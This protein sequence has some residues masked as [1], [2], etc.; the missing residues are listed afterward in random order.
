[1]EVNT[2]CCDTFGKLTFSC[3]CSL[4]MNVAGDILFILQ[5]RKKIT[6][7]HLIAPFPRAI[8][9]SFTTFTS[10]NKPGTCQGPNFELFTIKPKLYQQ[11]AISEQ[12]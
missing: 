9:P 1:M 8:F 5:L 11:A 3:A 4:I 10:E 2:H 12:C 6:H 7:F